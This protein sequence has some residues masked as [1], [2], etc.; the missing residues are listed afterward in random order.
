M[1]T[2]SFEELF[3]A[4]GGYG[5]STIEV[6]EN[7]FILDKTLVE[8]GLKKLDI[9]VL[10]VERKGAIIPNPPSGTKILL[11]DKLICFGK[12][13]NIKKELHIVHE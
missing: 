4:T 13:E 11:G 3:I 2:T 5:V 1:D 6:G 12:L 9:M 8:S 10:A 7:F